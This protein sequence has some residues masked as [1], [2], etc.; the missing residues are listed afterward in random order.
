MS[1]Q[2]INVPLDSSVYIPADKKK[3]FDKKKGGKQAP[4]EAAAEDAE[5]KAGGA[6]GGAA[7]GAAEGAEKDGRAFELLSSWDEVPEEVQNSPKVTRIRRG[8]FPPPADEAAAMNLDRC[9]RLLPHDDNTGECI[10]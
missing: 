5:G 7:D 3:N 9:L 6:A 2:P 10:Q 4:G 1:K 8:M